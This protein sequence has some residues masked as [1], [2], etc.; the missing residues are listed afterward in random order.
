MDGILTKNSD[1]DFIFNDTLVIDKGMM[2][3]CSDIVKSSEG[4]PFKANLFQI[5]EM[6]KTVQQITFTASNAVKQF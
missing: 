4:E 6:S 5:I 2:Q 3:F 1:T